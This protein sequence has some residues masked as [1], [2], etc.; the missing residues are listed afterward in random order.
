M[1]QTAWALL[2]AE[3][4]KLRRSAPVRLALAAPALLFLLELLTLFSRR[5]VNMTDPARLWR[6]L[7]SFGWVLW[8]GL[9]TPALIAF[10]AICLAAL[11]HG[12]RQWKQLFALPVPRWSIFAVKMLVCGV[13]VAASFF[14]FV[15]TS[16][17][18]VLMFS[19][20]RGL[21]LAASIPWAEILLTAVRAYAACWFLI[22]VQSWLSSRF[23]GFAVPA[24]IAF[25]A[26]LFGVVL[27]GV[28]R[29]YFGWWYPWTLPINVRPEGLY[30]AHNTLAPALFGA[31][32]GVLLAPVA[33]WDLGRRVE[34]V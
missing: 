24:G 7:L 5:T 23:A 29:E 16:V 10:E 26:M 19:G 27:T 13:L 32:A 3:A 14:T 21:H 22:V 25:A 31:I 12:G 17:A 33:S 9:F 20:A 30:D 2:S 6:D 4:I 18:G 1:M 28:G 34:D 8:L 15:A 11:E